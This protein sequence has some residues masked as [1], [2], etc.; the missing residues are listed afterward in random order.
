MQYRL[1]VYSSNPCVETC[2]TINIF[3]NRH[4]THIIYPI[5]RH[6]IYSITNSV[7]QTTGPACPPFRRLQTGNM[8]ILLSY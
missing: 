7:F 4:A 3:A 6:E 8:D 5:P 2:Q 1:S